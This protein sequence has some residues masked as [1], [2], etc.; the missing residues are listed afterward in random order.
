MD[1]IRK[2]ILEAARI[3]FILFLIFS[4][5]IIMWAIIEEQITKPVPQYYEVNALLMK[6]QGKFMRLIL[7]FNIICAKYY[8][9]DQ[10]LAFY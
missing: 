3:F 2:F 6:T 8:C 1:D 7:V 5:S 9:E 4:A 10:M